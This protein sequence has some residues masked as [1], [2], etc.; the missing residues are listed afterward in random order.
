MLPKGLDMHLWMF[1]NPPIAHIEDNCLWLKQE[2]MIK[3]RTQ[4]LMNN[5]M[6]R[7]GQQKKATTKQILT[8]KLMKR[9]RVVIVD[10]QGTLTKHQHQ[11]YDHPNEMEGF[12]FYHNCR[13]SKNLPFIQI[14]INER[15]LNVLYL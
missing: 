9:I 4:D 6:R 14:L 8:S 7:I 10:I 13:T 15:S 11:T 12:T 1:L 5:N 2:L 3:A